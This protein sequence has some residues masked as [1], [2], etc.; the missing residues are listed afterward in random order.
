MAWRREVGGWGNQ[1]MTNL[2]RLSNPEISIPQGGRGRHRRRGVVFPI[3]LEL[4]DRP[5]HWP[6]AHRI[7]HFS[8]VF[9]F[10]TAMLDY[11]HSVPIHGPRADEGGTEAPSPAPL[12]RLIT[13]GGG[14]V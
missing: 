6:Q 14:A 11:Q 10:L 13:E 1:S 8:S 7:L 3:R 2:S 4:E 9:Y 12:G 5:L